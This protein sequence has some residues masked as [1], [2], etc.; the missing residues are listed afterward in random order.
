MCLPTSMAFRAGDEPKYKELL[1]DDLIASCAH[2]VGPGAFEVA[3][4]S[5]L[6]AVV[7]VRGAG[8]PARVSPKDIAEDLVRQLDD[9]GAAQTPELLRPERFLTMHV[10]W[11]RWELWWWMKG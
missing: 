1:R 8:L 10:F 4:L 6:G 3:E 11:I 5:R 9:A 7:V 2:L